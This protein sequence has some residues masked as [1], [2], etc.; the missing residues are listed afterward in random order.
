MIRNFVLTVVLFLT[1]TVFSAI[2]TDS[3]FLSIP[4][5]LLPTISR[6]QR[7]EMAEY[8]KAGKKDSVPNIFGKN[9]I[10]IKYDTAECHIIIRTSTTG[11]TEIK[12]INTEKGTLTGIIN[13][14]NSPV[15][16][17]NLH[18]YS[19]DWRPAN[20]SIS[21]PDYKA[22]IDEMKLSESKIEKTWVEKLLDKKYYSVS[23]GNTNELIVGNNVLET[24]CTEDAN[25][26]KPF[27]IPK[28]I[29][30]KF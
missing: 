15:K 27:F 28:N 23:F 4:D 5:N 24:L 1:T 16:T 25:L 18:F 30:V 8:F 2:P 14:V 9:A 7:F 21:F 22:W 20:Y 11:T 6:K 29:I 12:R 13:T 17:S 3:L 19:E 10:L 26:V